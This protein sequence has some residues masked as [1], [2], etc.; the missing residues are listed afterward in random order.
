MTINVLGVDYGASNGK[1]MIGSFDGKTLH[2]R[3]IHRFGNRPVSMHPGVYWDILHLYSEL[4]T[5]LELTRAAVP[6]LSS[7]GIDGWSQDFGILD[8][9]GNLIGLPRCYRDPWTQ[10]VSR[11]IIERISAEDLY[12]RTGR[13]PFHG[14]TLFQLAALSKHAPSSVREGNTLL[15]LPSLLSFWLS[16]RQG[17]DESLAAASLLYDSDNRQWND[18]LL[19]RIGIPDILPEVVPAG[20]ASGK[21]RPD[22]ADA[23]GMQPVQV[24]TVA[25]HDTTSALLPVLADRPLD[26]V[27]I[28]CGTWSIAAAVAEHRIP[29]LETFESG[30]C[31]EPAFDENTRLLTKY[32]SGM[33]ILQE[34]MKEWKNAGLPTDYAVLQRGAE[35]SEYSSLIP[36]EDEI[37]AAPGVMTSKIRAYCDA[38]GQR[39]PANPAETYRCIVHSIVRAYCEAVQQLTRLTGRTIRRIQLIGG[40]SRDV[41]LCQTLKEASGLEVWAGPAESSALGNILMQLAS[42]GEIDLRRQRIQPLVAPFVNHVYN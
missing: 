20:Q 34:C 11:E 24:T 4:F 21:L 42:L 15:F 25:Q 9:Q 7:I 17:C 14:N 27:A 1:G 2:M 6:R 41:Y 3:E 5:C 29:S 16:G 39:P 22:L 30:F 33:W 12:L 32:M 13:L 26:T 18:H 8:P 28:I 40:G 35:D 23:L 19:A 10:E 31:V 37:F 38:S 36:I